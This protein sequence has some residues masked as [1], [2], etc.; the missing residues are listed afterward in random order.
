MLIVIHKTESPHSLDYG[1]FCILITNITMVLSS[2]FVMI[3]DE[4]KGAILIFLS[5]YIK[6]NGV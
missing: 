1:G 2:G 6:S 3:K 5:L 4:I